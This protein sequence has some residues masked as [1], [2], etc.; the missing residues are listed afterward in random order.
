[1]L[2][3][4]VMLNALWRYSIMG[5][6]HLFSK[7]CMRS[8]LAYRCKEIGRLPTRVESYSYEIVYKSDFVT[9]AFS[10]YFDSRDSTASSNQ[11]SA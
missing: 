5:S 9:V 1:M 10:S 7:Q 4:F 8:L 2:A 3:V 11:D 6:T